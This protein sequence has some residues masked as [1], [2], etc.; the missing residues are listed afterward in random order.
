MRNSLS[1]LVLALA[2]SCAP[3]QRGH[4][5]SQPEKNKAVVR[6][7]FEALRTG[8]LPA[9]NRLT[10]HEQKTGS[11]FTSLKDACPL[12]VSVSPREVTIDLMLAENDLVTVVSTLRGTQVGQVVGVPATGRQFVAR[13]TNVYRVQNGRIVD[14]IVG[15]DR[16]GVAQ[17][18][19]MK[20]CPKD[21]SK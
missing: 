13:Y 20:L 21:S 16:L 10:D 14:N 1:F 11:P 3:L 8:D 19:G 2:I 17:Q 12:C 18:L 15:L 5:D 7:L 6:E 9:F 4:S